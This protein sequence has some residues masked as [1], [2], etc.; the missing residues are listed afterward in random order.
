MAAM[1]K[2]LLWMIAVTLLVGVAQAQDTTLPL[3]LEPITAANA[4]RIEPLAVFGRGTI[5]RT[6]WSPDGKTL[7]VRGSLGLWLYSAENWESPILLDIDEGRV[8]SSAFSPDSRF[9]A[10]INWPFWYGYGQTSSVWE[11][12]TGEKRFDIRQGTKVIYSP[13]GESLAIGSDSGNVYLLDAQTG[14]LLATIDAHSS[15]IAD[16]TFSPDGTFIA[17]SSLDSH[18]PGT[19][20][21]PSDHT[22]R[23]W[24]VEQ[25][26]QDKEL[27]SEAAKMV[28]N[29]VG[30]HVYNL[31]LSANNHGLAYQLSECCTVLW[32]LVT[33][34]KLLEL[35]PNQPFAFDEDAVLYQEGTNLVR[36]D[37]ET[38][39]SETLFE[40]QGALQ[41][42]STHGNSPIPYTVNDGTLQMWGGETS[43]SVMLE[44]ADGVNSGQ[45]NHKR[46]LLVVEGEIRIWD[47][48]SGAKVAALSG[49]VPDTR[50]MGTTM[51]P[52]GKLLAYALGDDQIHLLNLETWVETTDIVGNTPLAFSP[53]N[54]FLAFERNQQVVIW[55]LVESTSLA[56]LPLGRIIFSPNGEKLV[57]L[58]NYDPPL[59]YDTE[60]WDQILLLPNSDDVLFNADGS[61]LLATYPY[62]GGPAAGL[63]DVE[64]GREI[65][66]LRRFGRPVDGLDFRPNGRPVVATYNDYNGFVEIF[67]VRRGRRRHVLELPLQLRNGV[68]APDPYPSAYNVEISPNGNFAAFET[69]EFRDT[70]SLYLWDL[71]TDKH[72]VLLAYEMSGLSNITFS[73][74]ESLLLLAGSDYISGGSAN[75]DRSIYLYDVKTGEQLRV[76][77]GHADPVWGLD[78]T[79]DNKL[80]VS[81]ST[82]GTVR[83]WGVPQHD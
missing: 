26:L 78:I 3:D 39:Q 28:L 29:D 57:V 17:S 4:S 47:I 35:P 69:Y 68:V 83:L 21:T 43:S 73:R 9:I 49:F 53:D 40:V 74:D 19:I 64:A 81:S 71:Q 55:D 58:P 22:V 13:N 59:I 45:V 51:S 20:I 48:D 80:I 60:T 38:G 12:A 82:D 50:R 42:E 76:L 54:R 16:I 41:F 1:Y 34:T 52:D 32:S 27:T 67:D 61:L 14:D 56:T 7:A 65:S 11:V 79:P 33:Q 18:G 25:A 63:W 66:N 44:D 8:V 6:V 2:S 30:D 46:L 75:L 31:Q 36:Y 23:I 37:M 72:R 24:D 62:V 70:Q 10:T 15:Q 5:G 77:T